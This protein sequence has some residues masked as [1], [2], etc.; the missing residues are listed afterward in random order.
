MAAPYCEGGCT[1]KLA[2][3][4]RSASMLPGAAKHATGSSRTTMPAATAAAATSSGLGL[5]HLY[6]AQR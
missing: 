3:T 6:C 5:S 4:R 2:A 1:P